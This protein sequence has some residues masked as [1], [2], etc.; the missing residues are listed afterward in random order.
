MVSQIGFQDQWR[1]DSYKKNEHISTEV[2]WR[3]NI[4]FDFV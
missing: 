2:Q 1:A 3:E 4:F